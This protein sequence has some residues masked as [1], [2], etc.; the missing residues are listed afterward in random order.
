MNNEFGRI[1]EE[2]TRSEEATISM[3]RQIE[4]YQDYAK[5]IHILGAEIDKLQADNRSLDEDAKRLRL[6]YA[7]NINFDKK[8]EAMNQ[9]LVLMAVEIEALRKRVEERGTTE[10]QMRKSILEPVRKINS[11]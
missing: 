6:K 4:E 2:A 11:K 3:G 5:R 10:E 7:D 9:K 8:E 1:L